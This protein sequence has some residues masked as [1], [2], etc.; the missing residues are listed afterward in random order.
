MAACW[1]PTSRRCAPSRRP[2]SPPWT[3]TRCARP[4]WR[5]CRRRSSVI[6][7]V[8]AGHPFDGEVG[9]GEAAR[10]F[11]GGVVPP[12]ADTIVIQ[13]NTKRDGDARHG[14]DG[15][16]RPAGTSAAPGSISSKAQVLLPKGRRLTDRD[17]M[18]AAAM[19]HPTLPVHRRPRV[20]VLGTGDELVPPGS[21]ARARRDRL[22]QRLC[23]DGAGPRRRRRGDR[24]RHRAGPGR[25]DGRGD[26][27]GARDA[28]PT[29]CSP[30]AAPRSATTTW[31]SRGSPPKGW[32]CRSGGWRC[33]P[34][35][36]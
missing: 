20:A 33:G 16:R 30:R 35:G 28:A 6:G 27:Q 29:S 10:I 9:A 1:P 21:D 5:R 11:T 15:R 12:G 23:A 13:E 3:A 26:P 19:N 8:A 31:C 17:L 4:T 32:R 36:R 18:L 14:H 7:E 34:A 2:I 24:S 22:F 25:G